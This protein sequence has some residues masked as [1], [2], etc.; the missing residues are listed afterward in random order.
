MLKIALHWQILIAIVLACVF[1][2]WFPDEVP[3]VAWMGDLFLRMLTMVVI[4]LVFCSIV[5][6]M[7]GIRGGKKLQRL[8]TKTV[9]LYFVTTLLAIL[10][11]LILVNLIRPGAGLNIIRCEEV[12]ATAL[13]SQTLGEALFSNLPKNPFG[14]LAEGRMLPIVFFAVI[15]GIFL[16]R[17]RAE[18]DDKNIN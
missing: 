16:A 14:D 7:T 15:F 9:A 4:P 8:G 5:A 3:Y 18:A 2:Y 6:A 13:Q 11:G 1:G 17:T 10:T 12:A